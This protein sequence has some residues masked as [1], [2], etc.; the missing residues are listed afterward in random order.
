M[1]NSLLTVVSSR[2]PRSGQRLR[3]C[4]AGTMDWDQAVAVSL[5]QPT[6]GNA[7]IST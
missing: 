6:S 7:N 2:R 5:V 3:E 4:A 1:G